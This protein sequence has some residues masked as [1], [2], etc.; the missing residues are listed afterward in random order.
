MQA[1]S[2]MN[3]MT[4]LTNRPNPNAAKLWVNWWLSKEG[5][6]LMHT[7]SEVLAE[8]TL[9]TD[10]TDWGTTDPVARREEGKSYFFFN[11]D[12]RYTVKRQEA[13]DYAVAAYEATHR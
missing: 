5:Q 6:T 4:T 12:P 9:R 2:G 13:L 10:V 7:N 1:T 8:P 11:T 3:F